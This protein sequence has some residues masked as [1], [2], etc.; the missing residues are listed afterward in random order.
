[1][2]Q[3]CP[4]PRLR[5]PP[6]STPSRPAGCRRATARSRSRT[7]G[8][9][10]H[11]VL[12]LPIVPGSD[13]EDAKRYLKTEKG[14]PA[15]NF[16]KGTF[17]S[18]IDGGKTMVIDVA[19]AEG[20][21]R[22]RVLHQ[23]PRRRQVPLRQGHDQRGDRRVGAGDRGAPPQGGAPPARRPAGGPAGWRAARR[24]ASRLSRPSSRARRSSTSSTR[25]STSEA[26]T[27]MTD[28]ISSS[29]SPRPTD[30]WSRARLVRSSPDRTSRA[31]SIVT[32]TAI[33]AG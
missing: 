8:E 22:P 14:K 6:R 9:E 15:V 7:A 12:A 19:L 16:E 4:R 31:C 5:S 18:V 21:L 10:P 33:G 2:T 1:M 3:S 26:S 17:S 32:A 20:R 29:C 28:A 27:C 25:R 30:R 11:H 13:F 24:A 23:R